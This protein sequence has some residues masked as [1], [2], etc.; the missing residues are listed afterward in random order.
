M[1]LISYRFRDKRDFSLELLKFLTF[2]VFSAA[3]DVVPLG[4]G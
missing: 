2:R 4:I 1:G 3:A